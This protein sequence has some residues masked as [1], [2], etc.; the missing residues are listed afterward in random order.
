MATGSAWMMTRVGLRAQAAYTSNLRKKCDAGCDWGVPKLPDESDGFVPDAYTQEDDVW[1]KTKSHLTYERPSTILVEKIIN[2][3][4]YFL[5]KGEAQ[6]D[7]KQVLSSSCVV[8]S[9]EL[10]TGLIVIYFF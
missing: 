9:L 7:A 2:K 4:D 10:S 1:F 3:Q 6:S 8:R 5:A